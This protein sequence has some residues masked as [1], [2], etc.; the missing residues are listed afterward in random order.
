MSEAELAD[1]L[2]QATPTRLTVRP[3]AQAAGTQPADAIFQ[4][5]STSARAE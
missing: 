5:S 2:E 3:G 1:V 4:R